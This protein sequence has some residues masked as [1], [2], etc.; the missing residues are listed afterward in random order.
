METPATFGELIDR[1]AKQL[2]DPKTGKQGLRNDQIAAMCG[3]LPDGSIVHGNTV[4]RIRQGL[5]VHLNPDL[6][7]RLIEVLQFDLELTTT[8]WELTGLA[9]P[10]TTADDIK[11]V[12][13]RIAERERVAERQRRRGDREIK[14][15][16]QAT[17]LRPASRASARGAVAVKRSC[18]PVL[19]RAA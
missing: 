9:P 14:N 17:D 3:L 15:Q 4:K 10:G 16:S 6:V 12:L 2:P 7:Q 5:R 11:A 13:Q 19:R 1:Q 18:T 8:A